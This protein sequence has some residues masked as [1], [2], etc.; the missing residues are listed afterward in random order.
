M[1]PLLLLAALATAAPDDA[2][3]P[4]S[5]RIDPIGGSGV[6]VD[7][8]GLVGPDGGLAVWTATARLRLERVHLQVAVPS[9]RFPTARGA[10]GALGTPSFAAYYEVR[11][12]HTLG[13][14][15]STRGSAETWAW[16][17]EP[18][19]LW[20]GQG[21]DLLWQTHWGSEQTQFVFQGQLGAHSSADY[22]PFRDSWVRLG[23]SGLVDQQLGSRFGLTGSLDLQYWDTSPIELTAAARADLIPGLRL[24]VGALLPLGTW[25]GLT[26]A[27][28][29][30]GV[31]ELTLFGSL[32]LAR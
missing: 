13:L 31:R 2:Q 32:G 25:A 22:A 29:D 16:L 23:V 21:I 11:P 28:R 8:A 5:P 4:Q 7:Y 6:Q 18:D 12:E 15:V 30:A 14:R 1:S 17:N 26:P 27:Q 3:A 19:E 10:D 9:A 24:R 20:P